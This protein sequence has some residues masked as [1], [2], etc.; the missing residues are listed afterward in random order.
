MI[1]IS[2]QWA[3]HPFTGQNTQQVC[4]AN[5]PKSKLYSSAT[6]PIKSSIKI[7]SSWPEYLDLI[8]DMKP[9]VRFTY[10]LMEIFFALPFKPLEE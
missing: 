2:E 8:Y 6:N 3:K 4:Y 1:L 10:G 9:N 5:W 7:T